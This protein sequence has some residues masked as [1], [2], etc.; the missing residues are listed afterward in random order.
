MCRNHIIKSKLSAI[1]KEWNGVDGFSKASG[2]IK[3]QI[4]LSR[5]ER[6]R[7]RYEERSLSI[8]PHSGRAMSEKVIDEMIHVVQKD[9]THF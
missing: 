3:R 6:A 2:A 9:E 8:A 1:E 4:P 7:G 5:F